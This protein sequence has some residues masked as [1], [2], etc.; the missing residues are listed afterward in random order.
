[1]TYEFLFILQ[2]PNG[3]VQFLG[4]QRRKARGP[5]QRESES[6]GFGEKP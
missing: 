1:M 3:T 4:I 5:A 6:V 2:R